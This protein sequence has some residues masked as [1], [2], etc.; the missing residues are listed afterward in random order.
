MFAHGIRRE[1]FPLAV[2]S[3]ML[4]SPLVREANAQSAIRDSA[5]R[6]ETRRFTVRDSIEMARFGRHDDE[7]L[8]SPDGKYLA[9]VT[10]RGV[11]ERNEVETTVRVFATEEVRQFLR[12]NE[13]RRPAP[14]VAARA[15]VTPTVVR[16]YSY[17]SI[18]GNLRWMPDSKHLLF[19]VENSSGNRQ[20]YQASVGTDSAKALTPA[21]QDVSQFD[22][23]AGTIAY[24]VTDFREKQEPGDRIN[25]DARDVTGLGLPSILFPNDHAPS[26]Y[27][28]L[29]VN[30]GLRNRPVIDS[31]TGQ[32]VH[33]WDLPPVVATALAVSPDGK[34]VVALVPVKELRPSWEHYEPKYAVDKRIDIHDPGRTTESSN[35]N[36]WGRLT[37]YAVIDLA[38][39]KTRPLV[40]APNGWALGYGGGNWATWSSDGKRLLLINTFLPFDSAEEP[41]KSKRVRACAAAVVDLIS[42]T[43]RCVSYGHQAN[44]RSS[45]FGQT[46]DDVV[47]RFDEQTP[48]EKFHFQKDTW[49]LVA[50]LTVEA[51]PLPLR[52]VNPRQNLSEGLSVQVQQGLNDPPVLSAMDCATGQQK[53]LWDP[54]PQLANMRLGEGS[55]ISWK[56]AS[57]YEWKGAVLKP[58]DYTPGKRY[59]LAIHTY[60][61]AEGEFL[62]DGIATTAFAA[63]PLAAAG[64]L[65]LVSFQLRPNDHLGK[66]Q[67]APEE[68]LGYESAIE[69]LVADGLVDADKVGI[70]GFSRTC[71]H[72]ES[73]LIKGPRRFAAATIADGVDLSYLQHLLF[74]YGENP[75]PEEGIYGARPYGE[76]LRTWVDRAP[77][78]HLDQVRTPLRIETIGPVSVLEEWET[79][80]SLSEQKKPVDLIY[81]P[82][83]QHI[84]QKPLDRMASQQGNVDWFRFWLK[85]E[86]DPDPAK[87]AQYVRWRELR[88]LQGGNGGQ[89]NGRSN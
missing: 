19:V 75:A 44:V 82:G 33:L 9:V 53:T 69:R 12:E 76:G 48:P 6:I 23:A 45:L 60:G 40:D 43:S 86:E 85:D 58:P 3:L 50:L 21:D 1:L 84:L 34:S 62:T 88:K 4:A 27:S 79:Y 26:N 61:F 78:F 5:A 57:G 66:A 31:E 42:M 41:E 28:T 30:Q 29:W 80:A 70:I 18:I 39:G 38:T 7:P 87:T 56:D 81:I 14:Q 55:I 11:I 54:N 10:S 67:E 24:R 77:G 52:C 83:G 25:A 49:Q 35:S 68:I 37:Q 22:C 36:S 64:I 74:F 2:G 72:V 20:L 46:S 51:P 47:L 71:N 13:T 89:R 73:A 32:P 63:R 65:V 16:Y 8:F 15:A 17:A 59:P